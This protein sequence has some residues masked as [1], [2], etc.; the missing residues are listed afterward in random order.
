MLF[1][2]GDVEGT[3]VGAMTKSQLASFLDNVV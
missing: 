3:R 1:K 2:N